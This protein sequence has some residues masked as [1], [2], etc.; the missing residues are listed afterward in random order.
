MYNNVD[1][2]KLLNEI[3]QCEQDLQKYIPKLQ[4]MKYQNKIDNFK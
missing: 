3:K 4:E 1:E 2:E